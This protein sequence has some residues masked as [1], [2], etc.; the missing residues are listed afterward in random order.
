MSRA[1]VTP[2]DAL[3][4]LLAAAK[5]I[6]A[7]ECK[8]ERVFHALQGEIAVAEG[9]LRDYVPSRVDL[10]DKVIAAL[11]A[12]QEGCIEPS[13]TGWQNGNGEEVGNRLEAAITAYKAAQ[14]AVAAAKFTIQQVADRIGGTSAMSPKEHCTLLNGDPVP[15]TLAQITYIANLFI[16][17]IALQGLS[18][19]GQLQ[20]AAPLH[21]AGNAAAVQAELSDD[22][23]SKIY[24]KCLQQWRRMPH[25]FP[26]MDLVFA[27]AILAA[28]QSPAAAP[29]IAAPTEVE[30]VKA[31]QVARAAL[32][33]ADYAIKGRE[34]T[35]FINNAIAVIDAAIATGEKHE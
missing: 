17:D 19:F 15:F 6:N 10:A 29:S 32:K 24:T 9:V 3:S 30:R 2:R 4:R 8:D 33:T 22:E 1:N 13:W 28:S 23:I 35:G 12:M 25:I 11:D 16:K 26:T 31:L 5:Q 21:E 20:D 7:D 18:D 34:H 27:R 14:S